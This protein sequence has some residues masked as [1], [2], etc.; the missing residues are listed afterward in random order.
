ML[1]LN[2]RFDLGEDHLEFKLIPCKFTKASG[3]IPMPD[4]GTIS[5]K[6]YALADGIHYSLNTDREIVVHFADGNILRCSKGLNEF[7]I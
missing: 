1:G 2:K 7:L 5:V 3:I 6:W 4:G